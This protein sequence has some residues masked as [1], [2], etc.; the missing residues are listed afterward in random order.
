[1]M[2]NNVFYDAD[3]NDVWG[4]VFSD[5]FD[6]VWT[7]PTRLVT[8]AAAIGGLTVLAGQV[9]GL[10]TLAAGLGGLAA[11]AGSAR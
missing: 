3:G 9:P 8:Q 5:V 11:E 6:G 4:G 1:M 7:R 10:A 2:E